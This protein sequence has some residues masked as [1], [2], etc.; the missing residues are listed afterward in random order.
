VWAHRLFEHVSSKRVAPN[1]DI[2]YWK[3]DF[4]VKREPQ[5]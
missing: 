3:P 5:A 2:S 1:P 4:G